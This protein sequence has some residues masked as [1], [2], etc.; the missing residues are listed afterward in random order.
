MII[1]IAIGIGKREI[2]TYT[3]PEGIA[4]N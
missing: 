3:V 4:A 2:N 1:D